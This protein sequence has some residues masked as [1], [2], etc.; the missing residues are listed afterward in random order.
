M[1]TTKKMLGAK[2]AEPALLK[3][4]FQLVKASSLG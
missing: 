3:E 2:A 1:S 4:V